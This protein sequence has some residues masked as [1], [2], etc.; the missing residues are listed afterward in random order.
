MLTGKR[1]IMFLLV[2]CGS[3]LAATVT[4]RSQNP[5]NQNA[6]QRPNKKRNQIDVSKWPAADYDSSDTV[7]ERSKR[8][9]ETKGKNFDKSKFEVNPASVSDNHVLTHSDTD[10]LSALPKLH[11]DAVVVG[12]VVDARA[13]LSNDKTGVYSE[14]S[15]MVNEVIKNFVEQPISPDD[16]IKVLREGGR[17]RL[18]SG[19]VQ[20]YSIS[21]ENM[22]EGQQRYVF[23]LR[24]LN[25]GQGFK[26]L[27][28]YALKNGKVFPLD[29]HSQFSVF[30][31]ADETEFLNKVRE[32]Q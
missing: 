30:K 4:L 27:T 20:F 11:S 5:D 15:V 13:Y 9:R 23:F 31:G 14:F 7:D 3:L 8:V 19:R 29:E 10:L 18:P 21:K 25:E 2:I 22:P 16:S 1:T 28:A 32:S 26:L 17:V 12:D 24:R 6:P